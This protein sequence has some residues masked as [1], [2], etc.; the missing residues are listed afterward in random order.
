MSIDQGEV[1]EEK[2]DSSF[3]DYCDRSRSYEPKVKLTPP[4]IKR[5]GPLPV[6][7]SVA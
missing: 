5:R 2:T 7:A 1:G 4:V 6:I 3:L